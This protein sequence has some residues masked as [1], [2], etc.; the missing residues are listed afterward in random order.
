ML[1]DFDYL[2]C[3]VDPAPLRRHFTF[4]ISPATLVFERA[5]VIGG[6]L[7]PL[8]EPLEIADIHRLDP[9]DDTPDPVWHI[10]GQNFDFRLRSDGYTQYLRQPPQHVGRQMLTSAERGGLSFDER[11]FV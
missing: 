5:W 2:V 4:W 1:L 11:A 6:D 9:P 3:W 10:E 7:G 8:H